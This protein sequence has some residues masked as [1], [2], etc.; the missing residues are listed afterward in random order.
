VGTQ[1]S[2]R[3]KKVIQDFDRY[4]VEDSGLYGRMFKIRLR[5]LGLEI[6]FDL[7]RRQ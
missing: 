7:F 4:V 2:W 1:N 5:E 6:E 3:R